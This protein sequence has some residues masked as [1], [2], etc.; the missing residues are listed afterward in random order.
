MAARA[1]CKW[2]SIVVAV[3][4]GPA[5]ASVAAAP[6]QNDAVAG[7]QSDYDVIVCTCVDA[8]DALEC[9]MLKHHIREVPAVA[10]RIARD[11]N[12]V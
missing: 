5:L 2:L 10:K 12:H 7:P 11:H 3:G 4:N 9:A 6:L 1:T 8:T